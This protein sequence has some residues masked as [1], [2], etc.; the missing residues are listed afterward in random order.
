MAQPN[1][2][3]HH[4][5][6]PGTSQ[7]TLNKVKIHFC[8]SLGIVI[9]AGF[10]PENLSRPCFYIFLSH[11]FILCH[12]TA[13]K[14]LI[15]PFHVRIPHNPNTYNFKP[16]QA[17]LPGTLSQSETIYR[18]EYWLFMLPTTNTVTPTE[19]QLCLY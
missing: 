6:T 1:R 16:L 15:P 18:S 5:D 14:S 7:S 19:L 3:I 13:P 17:F 10:L 9:P 11:P 4:S 12:R 8:S 2:A